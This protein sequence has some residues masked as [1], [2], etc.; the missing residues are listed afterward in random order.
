MIELLFLKEL[1][2]ITSE[3]KE[4]DICHYWY[5]LNKRFELQPYICNKCHDSLMISM[6]LS[7]IAILNIKVIFNINVV[8]LVELA[9]VKQ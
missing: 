4:Y 9:K 2:L 8:L 7:N 3:P 6:N 1:M 5:F